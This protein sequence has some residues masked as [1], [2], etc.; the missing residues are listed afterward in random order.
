MLGSTLLKQAITHMVTVH[1]QGGSKDPCQI[2]RNTSLNS[3]RGRVYA[4]NGAQVLFSFDPRAT[5]I[6]PERI[7]ELQ[8][9]LQLVARL[10]STGTILPKFGQY[11]YVEDFAQ[12]VSDLQVIATVQK[13]RQVACDLETIGLD[14]YAPEA[15]VV[16]ISLTCDEG[17]SYV[18]YMP[19]SGLLPDNVRSQLEW[20]LTSPTIKLV[21][22][23]FKF[24]QVWMLRHFGL[25][26]TN[27][28]FDTMLV[29]SLLN[30]NRC[31]APETRLLTAD[32][33][34]V[35]AD[36]LK[37]GDKVVGFD[38]HPSA[39]TLHRRMRKATV[40]SAEVIQKPR[41]RLTL[42]NG[43]SITVSDNHQFI[44]RKFPSVAVRVWRKAK[45][46]KPGCVIFHATPNPDHINGQAS[47]FERGRLSGFLDGEGSAPK[48]NDWGSWLVGWGQNPGP[49]H[50]DM[51]AI[52]ERIGFE[53]REHTDKSRADFTQ[54]VG[55]GAWGSL[56]ALIATRPMRLLAKEP[57]VNGPLPRPGALVSV[58]SVE[59]L[60]LGPVVALETD[61]HTFIAEGLLSHNSNSL[62]MHTKIYV[63]DLGGYDDCVAPETPVLT[64]DLRWVPVGNIQ[65]GDDLVGFDETCEPGMRRKL[66]TTTAE[67]TKRLIKPGCLITFSDG[68]QIKCSQDHGFLAHGNI[69]S[70]GPYKW[71]RAYD[72]KPGIRVCVG[73]PVESPATT[74]AAGYVS[75]LYDGEGYVSYQG[76]GLTSGISQK[77]GI[78][79]DKYELLMQAH[80]FGGYYASAKNCEGV[81]TSKHSGWTTLRL[82]QVFRPERLIAKRP[83]EGKCV[84]SG[85]PK[86]TVSSVE[87]LDDIEVVSLQTSTHTFIANGICS[88]N[89][90]NAKYDKGRMDLVPKDDFLLYAGGDTDACYRVA[91]VQRKL[92][93]K[94]KKLTNFYV[95]LL[96]PAATV[97]AKL[98]SRGVVV[99]L[100]QYKKL[101][102]ECEVALDSL[103]KQALALLPAKIRAKYA[104]DLKLTRDVI[105]REFLFTPRG[106]NLK[107]TVF[108]EK[109]KLPSCAL[110][111]LKTFMDHPEAKP[112][113]E[114]LARH[115][116]VKKT[117][118]TYII[119]FMKHLRSDG[120]FH[121]TY[122]MGRGSSIDDPEAGTVT[123]RLSAKDP[124]YQTIP[125]RTIWAKPLRTVYV[126]PPGYGILKAD[127][128]QG[129]L[130]ITAVL[131]EEP[132]MIDAYRKGLDLHA[133]TAAEIMG[134]PFEQF[135][136]LDP[137]VIEESRRA[138][139]AVNFGL[140][141][142]MGAEGLQDYSA[143]SYGVELSIDQSETYI[144]RF[145]KLY[146]RL[147]V[148]HEKY[149]KLAHDY[150]YIRNPLG[151]IRHL[152][153]IRSQNT[154]VKSRQERQAVN[155]PVQSCLSDA[156]LL[157]MVELDRRYP[158]LWMF[159]M[160]H[161]S[162]EVY[163][164]LDDMEG[165]ARKIKEVMENLPFERFGW[166]PPIR[167][168]V[169]V[170]VGTESLATVKKLKLAA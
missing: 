69:A 128:S 31:V 120:R 118:S 38:E 143:K 137:D 67:S 136:Q 76:H 102:F 148:W 63:N 52:A 64:A 167:F 36:S 43:V 152:P 47:D 5:E 129:E 125:K 96:Q 39:N 46:I 7:P 2:K 37:P 82:L 6:E 89:S 42:S 113:I 49:T 1:E 112:F 170:E 51:R 40:V 155:S 117:L 99:D 100:K 86:V 116:S 29:G 21:G 14:P 81:K 166:H 17:I 98:E 72:L 164:P 73:S 83:Y 106:L 169:D 159:G 27:Q 15:R 28:T 142:G 20:V 91:N 138:A 133:I 151:R 95:N 161:D 127:Y 23:N 32:L 79:W 105:L 147:P 55:C 48:L 146:N 160:T 45:N 124:A 56:H 93:V 97:F 12:V 153:L 10:A 41:L 87:F 3:A 132:T 131:A 109:E 114:L 22:A 75:G 18:Y 165:W 110:D 54:I 59:D 150:G 25:W 68:R 144:E 19:M 34:Y 157:A 11:Q 88:H 78:V 71:V 156:M 85:A 50:Q 24:D 90:F 8:W 158:D 101:E 84:P 44:C 134:I 35:R 162:L 33:R 61:T 66:R 103:S 58:V 168:Q 115:S 26:C 145:F 119:G 74:Y 135:M 149:K 154:E 123:G 16:S 111:H 53:F 121:P 139:K 9:D 163:I 130:R 30:E 126:P 140:I 77:P 4:V 80:G 70:N 122:M 62:N 57:W 104:D 94:D 107:P 60:G 92:L 108:T 65:E 13:P 141:Y